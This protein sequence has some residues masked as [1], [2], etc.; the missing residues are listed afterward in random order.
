MTVDTMSLNEEIDLIEAAGGGPQMYLSHSNAHGMAAQKY[1]AKVKLIAKTDPAQARLMRKM[2]KNHQAAAD[3]LAAIANGHVGHQYS[4]QQKMKQAATMTEE[5]NEGKYLWTVRGTNKKSG[6]PATV[7][8]RADDH[9]GAKAHPLAAPLNVHSTVKHTPDDERDAQ[10]AQAIK[11]V[12]E[13]TED[14]E[15]GF[16]NIDMNLRG[17]GKHV[18]YSHGDVW[19]I[20]KTGGGYQA[21]GRDSKKMHFG[22]TLG[23]ISKKLES[24]KVDEET[25]INESGLSDDAH[26]LVLHS[27]ND[28]H[29]YRSSKVPVMKNLEKKFKAGK[30]DHEKA[31]TLWKYHADRAGKSYHKEFGH[32][33]SP[34][35]RREAASHW[36]DEHHAEM[37]AGNFHESV[38]IDGA[39]IEGMLAAVFDEKPVAFMEH[40]DAVL[41]QI[42]SD[43]LDEMQED[44]SEIFDGG[45]PGSSTDDED[46]QDAG[47]GDKG[48]YGDGD[49]DEDD[50]GPG[51]GGGTDKK[52]KGDQVDESTWRDDKPESKPEGRFG[53]R[54]DSVQK[55]I[56]NNRTGKIG[57]KEGR[58][59]HALLKGRSPKPK[60]DEEVIPPTG[61]KVGTDK[62]ASQADGSTT[63]PPK[64]DG[65]STGKKKPNTGSVKKPAGDTFRDQEAAD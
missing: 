57:K 6:N 65:T 52:D 37:K 61:K 44:I 35:V 4:Q 59:I 54:K 5:I 12:K 14:L 8:V 47:E 17:K 49:D 60:V 45:G 64:I 2:G 46:N 51:D 22:K 27:D 16:H 1:M 29:Q 21:A 38:E 18:G 62:G 41:R 13:D 9:A 40:V 10:R 19:H 15:E 34:A 7:R 11:A 55:A 30:Y 23:H 43:R 33:H 56:D 63:T 3:A 36:A 48:D 50:G 28:S 39:L 26:E 42:A 58:M 24:E 31:K 25:M 53:Y 32:N 20:T